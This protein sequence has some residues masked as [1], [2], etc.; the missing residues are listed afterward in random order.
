MVPLPE[1]LRGARRIGGRYLLTGAIY[2]AGSAS[3]SRVTVDLYAVDDGERLMRAEEIDE[4]G[5]LEALLGRLALESVRALAPREGPALGSRAALF[6][7]TSSAEAVG[8]LL[9]GQL[10]FWN[11]DYDGAASA[12]RRA[13]EADSACGLAYHRL[14]V[15]ELWSHDFAAALRAADAGLNRAPALSP[16]WVNLLQAQRHYALRQGDSAIAAFQRMVLNYPDEIDGWLGLGDVLFHFAG[17]GPNIPL[18]AQRALGEVVSLDSSFAPIYDHLADL[19]FL[20]GD[21]QSARL[22]VERIPP[23]DIARLALEA[24]LPLRFGDPAAR[25]AALEQLRKTDRQ[26]ISEL[27]HLLIHGSSRLALVDTVASYL[28]EPDRTPDDRR[29]GAEYRLAALAA[30]GR[31]Q[32]GLTIWRSESDGGL[33]GWVLQAYFAGYPVNSVAEPMLSSAKAAVWRQSRLDLTGLPSTELV[34]AVQALVHRATLE[35]DSLEVLELLSRVSSARAARDSS[36]P[37]VPAL[38]ASLHA[39]LALLAG[40]TANAINLLDRSVGRSLWPYTDFFPLSGMAP[41]RLLLGSLLAAR[42]QAQS[43]K[44]WLDSFSNSWAVGD[45]FFVAR[46]RQVQATVP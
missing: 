4:G 37:L 6:S 20:R 22:Y 26:A 17:L 21:A 25:R 27:V 8:H 33:D 31:P 5:R 38:A 30:M 15:A 3:G 1:L 46:A 16:K 43:A 11:G 14:S 40:D 32:E 29:R 23:G 18:D 45:V 13:V 7:A 34:Q 36:D 24:A 35:G 10:K 9:Q 41:Q 19:A 2:P 44:R 28:M 42:G 12:F 39:R